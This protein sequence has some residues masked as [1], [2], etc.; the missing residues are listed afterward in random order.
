M[1]VAGG[2]N[3][4]SL[5][6]IAILLFE[7]STSAI[8]T[9]KH[10]NNVPQQL[11]FAITIFVCSP[12]LQVRKLGKKHPQIF[13]ILQFQ[14]RSGLLVHCLSSFSVSCQQARQD[15]R[16]TPWT[17]TPLK[18][19][20]ATIQNC[21]SVTILAEKSK[22]K[23][24]NLNKFRCCTLEVLMLYFFCNTVQQKSCHL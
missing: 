9:P 22:Q 7:G 13:Q 20:A 1:A 23:K 18:S 21:G 19:D 10:K 6:A 24:L 5:S 17:N 8:T 14:I 16:F 2:R 12:Q 4:F 15:K 3:L 11:Q